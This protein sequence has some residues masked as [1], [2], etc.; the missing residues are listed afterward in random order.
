MFGKGEPAAMMIVDF[1]HEG[2]PQCS[3]CSGPVRFRRPALSIGAKTSREIRLPRPD[4]RKGSLVGCAEVGKK[5][6][7]TMCTP[8]AADRVVLVPDWAGVRRFRGSG[9]YSRAG[10]RFESHLGHVFPL[11]RGVL[12]LMCVH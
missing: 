2:S 5:G 3:A 6:V 4:G 9:G 8:W 1:Q 11:V 12:P 7:C 10:T